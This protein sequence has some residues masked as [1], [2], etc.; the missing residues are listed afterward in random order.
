MGGTIASSVGTAVSDATKG[1]PPFVDQIAKVQR[2]QRSRLHGRFQ[3]EARMQRR[4]DE[5]K[6]LAVSMQQQEQQKQSQQLRKR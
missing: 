1:E 6:A 4:W 3:R 5:L 2:L